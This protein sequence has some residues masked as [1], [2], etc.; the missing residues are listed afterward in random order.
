[1]SLDPVPAHVAPEDAIVFTD[2]WIYD[3]QK[4]VTGSGSI[5]A[6]LAVCANVQYLC[7]TVLRSATAEF[8]ESLDNNNIMCTDIESSVACIEGDFCLKE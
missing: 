5:I 7:V 2:M 1:M 4:S 8:V 6:P 3:V